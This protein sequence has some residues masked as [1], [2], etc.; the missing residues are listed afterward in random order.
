MEPSCALVRLV[1]TRARGNREEK[2]D[3]EELK[4]VLEGDS[5][6]KVESLKRPKLQS[7]ALSIKKKFQVTSGGC[8][9]DSSYKCKSDLILGRREYE[10]AL[11]RHYLLPQLLRFFGWLSGLDIARKEKEETLIVKKKLQACCIVLVRNIGKSMN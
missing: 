3:E 9:I 11:A 5:D 6:P 4:E 1:K 2:E 8:L 7:W 10:V